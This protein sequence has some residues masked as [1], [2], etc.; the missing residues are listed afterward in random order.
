M[1]AGLIWRWLQ[2][3]CCVLTYFSSYIQWIPETSMTTQLI[4]DN[5]F[6]VRRKYIHVDN[7]F[8]F[9]PSLPFPLPFPCILLRVLPVKTGKS[10]NSLYIIRLL[11]HKFSYRHNRD[12]G[13][14]LSPLEAT[15][16]GLL[17]QGEKVSS[18]E[19]M[20]H[21]KSLRHSVPKGLF[22]LG[23]CEGEDGKMLFYSQEAS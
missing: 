5:K 17:F 15:R 23:A 12:L 7:L 13:L 8:T 6:W 2:T 1:V 19:T 16:N 9:S 10:C 3:H 14:L 4:Q 21:V 18:Y 22:S 11:P 20:T